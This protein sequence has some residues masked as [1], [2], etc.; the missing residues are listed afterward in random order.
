MTEASCRLREV[1]DSWEELRGPLASL[2]AAAAA[3]AAEAQ[4]KTQLEAHQK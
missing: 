3:A 2:H 1:A 4:Q